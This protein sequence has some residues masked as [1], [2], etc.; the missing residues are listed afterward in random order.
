MK[1]SNSKSEMSYSMWYLRRIMRKPLNSVFIYVKS[2][3]IHVSRDIVLE[4]KKDI[5][6]I[7]KSFI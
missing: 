7:V 2:G 1:I 5:T 3:T 6:L 4:P